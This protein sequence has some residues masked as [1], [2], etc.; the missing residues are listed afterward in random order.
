[1]N[2]QKSLTYF[3]LYEE[4]PAMAFRNALSSVMLKYNKQTAFKEI[5]LD[6]YRR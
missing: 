3:W 1:M 6:F 2:Q 4:V 5:Q